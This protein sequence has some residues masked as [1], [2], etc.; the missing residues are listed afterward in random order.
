MNNFSPGSAVIDLDGYAVTVADIAA[1]AYGGAR[2]EVPPAALENMSAQRSAFEEIASSNV[3]VYGVTTGYGEMVYAAVDASEETSLQTNLVRSHSAGTGPAFSVPEA[4]AIVAARINSLV[5]GYSAVRP[6]LAIH[7]VEYLNR[8]VVPMIPEIGSLGA[9]G[10]LGPLAHLASTVIGEGYTLGEDGNYVPTAERLAEVE[11]DPL[12]LKFKEGLSLINGTSAMTGVI[13]LLVEKSKMQVT[14]AEII[15]AL[16]LEIMQA[17]SSAFLS[18]GH[19]IA[20]P[21]AG[22]AASAANIRALI[23]GSGLVESHERLRAEMSAAKRGTADSVAITDVYLQ[24][25][26]S[27][28]CIPQILGAVRDTIAHVEN[29]VTIELNSSNDNPLFFKDEEVFHGGNFHGQPVAFGA[30]FLGISMIQ[31]GVLS[32]RRTNRL[33]NRH[34]SNGLPEFLAHGYP[35]LKSGMAGLQY[36]ATATV[37]ENRTLAVPASIQSIPSNGDNQDVVSMGLIG[38]RKSRTIIE[39]NWIPLAVEA[40][41]A[42]QAVHLSGRAGDLGPAGKVAF[43]ALSE[44][45]PLLEED[46]YMADD[47]S[48]MIDYLASGELPRRLRDAGVDLR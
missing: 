30:D 22:Q 7:L 38:A 44:V 28:R 21:H 40:M 34:L 39:N 11:L 18:H 42:V 29:V 48:R 15:S 19:N 33:L 8:G 31:V 13:A 43:T 10:D 16:I 41:A 35:G 32:E 5:R 17:S 20:R 12:T 6:E 3:P 9:S 14:S 24:K 46:R 23:E 45:F 4:R 26:Y 27:L 25:A 37:A 47:L 1:I 2:V 36:P